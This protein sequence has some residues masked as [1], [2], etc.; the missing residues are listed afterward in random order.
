VVGHNAL[1]QVSAAADDS[2]SMHYYDTARHLFS[3]ARAK[4]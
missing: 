4:R 2:G 1:G 3:R